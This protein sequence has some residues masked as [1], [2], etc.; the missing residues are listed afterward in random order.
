MHI[1]ILIRV[2]K[3]R[4]HWISIQIDKSMIL[5]LSKHWIEMNRKKY[6]KKQMPQQRWNWDEEKKSLWVSWFVLEEQFSHTFLPLHIVYIIEYIKRTLF[7]ERD[8]HNFLYYNFMCTYLNC[9][10]VKMVWHVHIFDHVNNMLL[11][12][13]L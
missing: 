10:N 8:R 1:L 12:C 3:L 2:H 6:E 5:T 9:Y 13:R 7:T 4:F 11:N